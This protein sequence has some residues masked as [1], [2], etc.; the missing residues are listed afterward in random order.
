MASTTGHV[1][2]TISYLIIIKITIPWHDRL[3]R[4]TACQATAD[5][6]FSCQKTEVS[7]HPVSL[8]WYLLLA[9]QTGITTTTCSHP[10]SGRELTPSTIQK[11]LCHQ[12]PN[13]HHLLQHH[14]LNHTITGFVQNFWNINKKM[15]DT[16]MNCTNEVCISYFSF[17]LPWR[18]LFW[19]MFR[20]FSIKID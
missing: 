8:E 19:A 20:P 12:L 15:T 6:M 1:L 16:I 7:N 11:S 14:A 13:Q 3:L 4:P 2:F 17:C 5:L 9:F 10:N 18:Q